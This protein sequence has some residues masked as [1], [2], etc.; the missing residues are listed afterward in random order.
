MTFRDANEAAETL[1]NALRARRKLLGVSMTAAAEAAQ[2][3]RVTWHRLEKGEPGVAWRY[4]LAAAA[5]LDLDVALLPPDA[6]EHGPSAEVAPSLE[7]WL[8]LT[9]ALDEFPGL[10]RLAWSIRAGRHAL[11]PREAWQLYERN[12]RHLHDDDLSPHER[13]LIRALGKT[14]GE[15]HVGV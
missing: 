2:M 4:L 7:N 10:A 8:P 5:T 12:G 9:I 14:F 3:S 11:A 15:L 6:H 1:G 13:A